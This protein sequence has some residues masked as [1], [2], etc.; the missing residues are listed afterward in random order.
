MVGN[1]GAALQDVRQV[2]GGKQ[3]EDE[4][5]V[6]ATE[7]E[8]LKATFSFSH[9]CPTSPDSLGA[10]PLVDG[11]DPYVLTERPHLYFAGNCTQF[12]TCTVTNNDDD[13]N[14]MDKNMDDNMDDNMDNTTNMTRLVCIPRFSQT[15]QAVLVHLQSLDCQV[16]EFKPNQED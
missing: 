13:D 4:I 5:M 1:D 9:T 15:G 2:L 14:N 16:L 6:P 12:D 11:T 8:A 7:L 10:M 3:N